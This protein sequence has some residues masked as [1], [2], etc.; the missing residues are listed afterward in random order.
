MHVFKKNLLAKP[1]H[2]FGVQCH[3]GKRGPLLKTMAAKF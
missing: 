2:E 3:Y 1:L